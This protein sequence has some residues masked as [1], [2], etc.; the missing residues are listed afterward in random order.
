MFSGK[1]PPTADAKPIV[2]LALHP[3]GTLAFGFPGLESDHD[4]D[5]D[6]EDDE[7]EDEDDED[8]T[9]D[10]IDVDD[11]DEDDDNLPPQNDG[12]EVKMVYELINI[13]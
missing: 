13:D 6:D 10:G 3:D 7:D 5:D 2:A 12:E 8:E 11:N 4:D 9:D 1:L